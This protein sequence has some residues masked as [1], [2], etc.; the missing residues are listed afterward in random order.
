MDLIYWLVCS[1]SR[2]GSYGGYRYFSHI[3]YSNIKFT[4]QSGKKRKKSKSSLEDFKDLLCSACDEY[5]A[6]LDEY[7]KHKRLCTAAGD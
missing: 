1:S 3:D 6:N 7:N 5:C 4:K 2:F